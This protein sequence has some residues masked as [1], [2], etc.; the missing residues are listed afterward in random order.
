MPVPFQYSYANVIEYYEKLFIASEFFTLERDLGTRRSAAGSNGG[1]TTEY[2]E[3]G[4]LEYGEGVCVRGD[5][6][7]YENIVGSLNNRVVG[8]T[9]AEHS[10]D[11][12]RSAE[13]TVGIKRLDFNDF[14]DVG[15]IIDQAAGI[16]TEDNVYILVCGVETAAGDGDF[17][18]DSACTYTECNAFTGSI[19]RSSCN[20]CCCGKDK[21][22][23]KQY[24]YFKKSHLSAC[25]SII[26]L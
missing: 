16:S 13:C 24:Q 11:C 15:S 25:R 5:V 21:C 23:R 17:L 12:K 22:C 20:S 18:P 8:G 10:R 7:G 3:R 9:S 4:Y 19:C 6:V 14:I 1:L 2:F 26:F